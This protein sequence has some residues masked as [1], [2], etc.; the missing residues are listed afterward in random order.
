VDQIEPRCPN[1]P[2]QAYYCL[3]RPQ[4]LVQREW[5]H[6]DPTL[7]KGGDATFEPFRY[8]HGH[9]IALAVQPAGE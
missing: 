8:S 1:Q 7:P 6:L 2:D 3:V 5:R 4:C 9:S